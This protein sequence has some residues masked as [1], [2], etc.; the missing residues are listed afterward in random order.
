MVT[1]QQK[2]KTA[3]ITYETKYI[4]VKSHEILINNTVSNDSNGIEPAVLC[5]VW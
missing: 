3:Y 4:I 2:N 1:L 5:Y